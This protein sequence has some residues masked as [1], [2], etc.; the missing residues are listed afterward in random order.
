MSAKK[1][2]YR[3]PEA[4]DVL[5]IG[6]SKTYELVSTGALELVKIGTRALITA[7]SLERYVD[8]LTAA[9]GV[10]SR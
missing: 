1:L 8:S 9:Q 5:G 3:V 2:L 10:E 6:R 4:M 7:E